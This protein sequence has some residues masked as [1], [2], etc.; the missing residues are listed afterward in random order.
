MS[1]PGLRG[2]AAGSSLI[3]GLALVD[4]AASPSGSDTPLR[5]SA[6]GAHPAAASAGDSGT[7]EGGAEDSA[8][9]TAGTS[10]AGPTLNTNSDAGAAGSDQI[11]EPCAADV[12]SAEVV[13]LDM[14]LMLD[15][16]ASMAD[17]VG[18]NSTKWSAVK[19][20]LRAFLR[21]KSAQ[22]LGVGLQYFPLQKP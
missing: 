21:S 12:T 18:A 8:P 20:A 6:A 3:A 9:V 22:G 11:D 14:Y 19:S 15:T 7:G 16:S 4:C 10:G 13:P 17:A 1:F 2:V 5:S